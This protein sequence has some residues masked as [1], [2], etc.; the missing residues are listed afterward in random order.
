MAPNALYKRASAFRSIGQTEQ[1]MA[2]YRQIVDQYPR[3]DAALLAQEFL[4]NR[5]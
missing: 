1:A 5:P 4:R 2:I 3:S